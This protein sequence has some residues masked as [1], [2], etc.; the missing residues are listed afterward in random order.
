MYVGK[1]HAVS[2]GVWHPEEGLKSSQLELEAVDVGA[3]NLSP[4]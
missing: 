4:L 2:A 1:V 3:R